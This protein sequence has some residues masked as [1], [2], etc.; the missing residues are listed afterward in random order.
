MKKRVLAILFAIMMVTT[1]LVACRNDTGPAAGGDDGGPAGNLAPIGSGAVQFDPNAVVNDGDPIEFDYW[2]WGGPALEQVWQ[3]LID[4]YVQFRPNVTINIVNQPWGELWTLLPLAM[5]GGDGP[6]IFNVHNAQN[7]VLVPFMVPY[8]IPH[9]DLKADFDN[10]EAQIQD[11]NIYY[12]DLGFMSSKIYYNREHWAEAGLTEGDYPQTWTELAEIAQ[13]LT[14]FDDNGHMIRSGFNINGM[15]GLLTI[16]FNYQQ[17]SRMFMDDLMTANI[18]N[19]YTRRSVEMLVAFYDH[20]NVVDRDFGIDAG[21]SFGIGHTSMV[22]N[23]G[24]F[25]GHLM[26]TFPDIDFGVFRLPTVDVGTPFAFDRFNGE[27]TMGINA[28]GTPA[29]QEVAQ[30]LVRFLLAN[31]EFLVEVSR[32][33][34]VIPSKRILQDD[35]RILEI[36]SL[37]VVAGMADRIIWPGP[38]PGTYDQLLGTMMENVLYLGMPIDE[39]LADIQNRLDN[40]LPAHN[41]R[42][43]ESAYPHYDEHVN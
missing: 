5:S 3:D 22:Y 20:Y 35:P 38:F 29:E 37:A 28:N 1:F 6:P 7:A 23:W 25:N 17:G 36:P 19:E 40:E 18:N 11:G 34:N 31:D 10:V 26:G 32:V 14:Q 15:G 4:E 9:E 21:E 16:T 33:Y 13:I 30:D 43:R 24:W 41:F 12:I 2:L 39:A 8:D 42:S 27:S